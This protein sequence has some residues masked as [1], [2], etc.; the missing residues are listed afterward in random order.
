MQRK[1]KTASAGVM[2]AIQNFKRNKRKSKGKMKAGRP[3][4]GGSFS[5]SR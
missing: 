4:S 5:I 3:A 2:V 1:T